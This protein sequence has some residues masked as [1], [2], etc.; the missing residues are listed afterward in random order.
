MKARG[1]QR[2]VVAAFVF[3]P[4]ALSCLLFLLPHVTESVQTPLL[5]AILLLS[6]LAAFIELAAIVV[7]LSRWRS[8]HS[9]GVFGFVGVVIGS[10]TFV[11]AICLVGLLLGGGGG[12]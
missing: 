8:G 1:S 6:P 5:T 11:G 2:I 9:L 12:V 4:V 3:P 7:A 10:G